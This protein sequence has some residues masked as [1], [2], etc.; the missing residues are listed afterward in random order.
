MFQFE[1]EDYIVASWFFQFNPEVTNGVRGHFITVLL[2]RDIDTVPHWMLHRVIK[3]DMGVEYDSDQFPCEGAESISEQ[4]AFEDVDKLIAGMATEHSEIYDCVEVRGGPQRF[5][6][7]MATKPYM[8]TQ[9]LSIEEA[10]ALAAEGKLPPEIVK[11]LEERKA[12][13]ANNERNTN[14]KSSH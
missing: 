5:C 12:K 3:T 10:E 14:E 2:K 11:A 6:N 1:K 9:T 7:M 8:G 13:N 4:R